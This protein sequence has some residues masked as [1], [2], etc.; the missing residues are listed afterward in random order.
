MHSWSTKYLSGQVCLTF[1]KL[2]YLLTQESEEDK[3]VVN[4]RSAARFDIEN[5]KQCLLTKDC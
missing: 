3:E 2:K 5:L 1:N 4:E